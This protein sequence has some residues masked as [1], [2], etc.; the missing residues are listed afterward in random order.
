MDN[1]N[2]FDTIP[3]IFKEAEDFLPLNDDNF[4]CNRIVRIIRKNSI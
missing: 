1:K 3:K 2:V 4:E